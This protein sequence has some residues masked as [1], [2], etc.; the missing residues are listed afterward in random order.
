MVAFHLVYDLVYIFEVNCSWFQ[1]TW[2]DLWQ[3]S[4]GWSFVF[5][6]GC[7]ASL[8]HSCSQ[9]ACKLAIVAAAITCVTAIVHVDIPIYFGVI[10]CLALSTAILSVAKTALDRLP[11]VPTMLACLIVAVATSDLSDGYLGI[12]G[13]ASVRLPAFLYEIDAISFIGFPGPHFASGDY[14]PL[15]PYLP[16]FLSGYLGFRHLV[17]CGRANGVLTKDPV[18]PLA[19]IGRHSLG[20][21]L[22][23]QIVLLVILYIAFGLFR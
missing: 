22:V 8:S 6:A 17:Q 12:A 2:G 10:H 5:I 1:G 16:L 3:L 15:L 13:I 20:I 18:P 11:A 7:S 19:F 21:Y 23:H 9:R 14:F 4:I